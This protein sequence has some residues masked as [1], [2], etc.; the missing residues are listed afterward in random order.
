MRIV[1][2]KEMDIALKVLIE[3]GVSY[4]QIAK[5]L[6]AAYGLKFTKNSCVG[7]A[8]RLRRPSPPPPQKVTIYDLRDD[9]CKWILG[10]VNDKPPYLYCGKPTGELGISWC[11]VHA[12]KVFNKTSDSAK[13]YLRA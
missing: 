10:A 5:Q 11:P 12:R 6:S 8:N 13:I 2:T 3:E 1:W 7:R 4:K 9:R